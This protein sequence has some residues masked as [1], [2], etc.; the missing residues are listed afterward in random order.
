MRCGRM[1]RP[2]RLDAGTRAWMERAADTWRELEVVAAQLLGT[3]GEHVVMAQDVRS[4][5]HDSGAPV[6]HRYIYVYTLRGGKIAAAIAYPGEA[7]AFEAVGL[8]E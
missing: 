8:S 1:R 7:E 6:E 2:P 3:V 5:G 4:T